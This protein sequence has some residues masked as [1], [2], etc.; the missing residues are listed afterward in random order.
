LFIG[1]GRFSQSMLPFFSNWETALW[2]RR[3]HDGI[4]A[5]ATTRLFAPADKSAA[6]NW[7]THLVLTTPPEGSHDDDWQ[8]LARQADVRHVIHLGRRQ[9]AASDWALLPE[10]INYHC[11]DDVFALRKRQSSVRDLN[12]LRARRACTRLTNGLRNDASNGST[13]LPLALPQHA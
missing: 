11:L 9:A 6:V 8:A 2:N 3:L 13:L 12:I 7:A 10:H 1:A 4:A 5:S